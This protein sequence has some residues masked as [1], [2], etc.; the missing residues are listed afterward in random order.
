MNAKRFF[1]AIVILAVSLS[2]C[3][4]TAAAT[5]APAATKAPMQNSIPQH[6]T[7]AS[8]PTRAPLNEVRSPAPTASAGAIAQSAQSNSSKAAGGMPPAG[9]MPTPAVP[10]D[11]FFRDYGINGFV[12][13]RADR[14][15]TFSLDV[16]TASYTVA[17][18][19]IRDGVL[20]PADAI[21]VEEFVNFFDQGYPQPPDVAFGVYADGAPSPFLEDGSHIL[22]IG[23]QGYDVPESD[24][25]PLVLTFVIDVSGSM[26]TDNR[27]GLVQQSLDLLVHRL[28]PSD[29]VAI[30]AFTTYAWIVQNPTPASDQSAILANI[31]SLSPQA[32]TN[33]EQGLNLGY[34]LADQAFRSGAS[35]RVILCSD[36]VANVGLTDPNGMMESIRRYADQGITL[37][38]IGVGMGNF[39][40]VLLEQ[41]ADKGDGNYA[42]VDT[43]EEAQ[44]VFVE[45]LT[46]TL[47]VIALDA[48]V[49]V[50]FNPDVV[51]RYR[52][53]GYENRAIADQNFRNDSVDAGEIGAGHSA[54]A[55]Y[56][57]QLNAGAQGR[58]ATVQ[59][60]WQDPTSREVKEING[61][62]NTW[63][64]A[65]SFDQ[66]PARYQ[67]AVVAAQY[68]EL[69]R[70][71]PYAA[72]T[73]FQQLIYYALRLASALPE[74]PDVREFSQL[75]SQAGE[76]GGWSSPD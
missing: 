54:T 9:I 13:S 27:L 50:D 38:A 15:S 43:L 20:P 37:T 12:D 29:S 42:Y 52:L 73:S 1:P 36:G 25:K 24:R 66:A 68:A 35:N 30:V 49:Q 45:D 32:A 76:L 26:A 64:L 56:A 10:Q 2:A 58:L 34:T 74:D 47:Q 44:R 7:S 62:V 41:L 60:R 71:S 51:S 53:I 31:Y 75:V 14:L 67:L 39:N 40:D 23:V 46:A 33:V 55:I 22:R 48:K 61:N 72:G 19:Y 5:Q 8:E 3:G 21:R 18:Q 65:R 11:N 17:R 4:A 57:I 63:D 69:L 59:L 70:N 6:A 16:D 28:R